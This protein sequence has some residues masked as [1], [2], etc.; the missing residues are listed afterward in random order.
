MFKQVCGRNRSI[1]L[2]P[3]AKDLG[4]VTLLDP[5]YARDMRD[6]HLLLADVDS[7]SVVAVIDEQSD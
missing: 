2:A 4:V 1:M 7:V 5:T 3:L 6:G